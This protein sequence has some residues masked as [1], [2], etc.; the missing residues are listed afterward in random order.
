MTMQTFLLIPEWAASPGPFADT[1]TPLPERRRPRDVTI[2]RPRCVS[3]KDAGMLVV[4][5]LAGRR[6]VVRPR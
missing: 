5:G 2:A 3:G 6:S 4:Q 1:F